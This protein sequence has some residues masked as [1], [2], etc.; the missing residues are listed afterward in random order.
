MKHGIA[1]DEMIEV[2]A[3]YALGALSQQEARAFENH[4]AERCEAC[5]S[6][7]ASFEATLAALAC[8]VEAEAPP[9]KVRDE[10]LAR[11][12]DEAQANEAARGEPGSDALKFVSIR[13]S[14]GEWLQLQK[15]VLVKQLYVDSATG[16]TTSLVRMQPGTSLP[17]HQHQ[18]VEQ[19]YIIEGDCNVRGEVLGPGD[20]HRAAAGSIHETTYTVNGT[21]FLLVAPKDYQVLNA[22]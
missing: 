19:L 1:P 14:E 4:L 9:V 15:G 8:A 2:A 18:G 12:R 3:S 20:Y 6:E 13:G 11:F 22:R 10:L 17:M 16:I 7:L 21:M 5:R